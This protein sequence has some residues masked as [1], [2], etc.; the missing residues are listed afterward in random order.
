MRGAP[1]AKSK[2]AT[3]SSRSPPFPSSHAATPSR[4][5]IWRKGSPSAASGASSSFVST[6]LRL[7]HG[8]SSARGAGRKPPIPPPPC[9]VSREP[10]RLRASMRSWC[11]RSSAPGVGIPR[12]G[13]SWTRRGRSLSRPGNSC[14]WGRCRWRG[15]RR[16]GWRR[17]PKR[18]GSIRSLRS[19]WRGASRSAGSWET[20]P[21]GVT[22]RVFARRWKSTLRSRALYSLP[23]RVSGPPRLGSGSDVRTSQR[24]RLRT[25][26]SRSRYA[27]RWRR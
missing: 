18:S 8:W 22:A 12:C 6:C 23:A 1:A 9:Y 11:S 17:D 7:A 19:T 26:T 4:S 21:A 25:P 14:G 2:W 27:G 16:R 15:R 20:S 10:R 3:S 5:G 13:R 24:L